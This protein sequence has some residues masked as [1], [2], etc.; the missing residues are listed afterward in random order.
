ML[1]VSDEYLYGFVDGEGCFYVGIVPSKE[2]KNH[3]QVITF[4]KVSQNPKGKVILDYLKKRLDCG[5]VKP[6]A[7]KNSTDKSLAFVVRDFL[8][9]KSKVIPFFNKKLIIKK[10]EFIKFKKIIEKIDR[11]EHLTKNGLKEII[12]IA[13]SMNTGKRKLTKQEILRHIK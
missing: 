1:N 9:L 4:F 11:N 6:N 12:D 3:F 2:T 8:S 10:S 7:S 13:Y 5:Y